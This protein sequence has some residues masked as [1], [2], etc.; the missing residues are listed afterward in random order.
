MQRTSFS[1]F[2]SCKIWTGS[3]KT[4]IISC[5]SNQTNKYQQSL[6][7][8]TCRKMT[9][10]NSYVSHDSGWDDHYTVGCSVFVG[11]TCRRHPCHWCLWWWLY[12]FGGGFLWYESVGMRTVFFSVTLLLIWISRD[13]YHQNRSVV[14]HMSREVISLLGMFEIFYFHYIF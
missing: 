13:Q 14:S 2:I 9:T 1:Y 5:C 8:N 11:I 6:Y 4:R 7:H 10:R 3:K 12:A